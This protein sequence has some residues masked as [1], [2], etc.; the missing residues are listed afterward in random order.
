MR[1]VTFKQEHVSLAEI[2]GPDKQAFIKNCDVL[3]EHLA[4]TFINDGRII[5]FAGIVIEPSSVGHV[6]L[7]PTKYLTKN[8]LCFA[9]AM[10]HYIDVIPKTHNLNQLITKGHEDKCITRWL[11]WLGFKEQGSRNG[12]VAYIKDV[13]YGN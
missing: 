11:S 10:K 5:A 12:E 4:G 9:R 8:Y 6:W 2:A 7:V 13:Y 1:I 3:A